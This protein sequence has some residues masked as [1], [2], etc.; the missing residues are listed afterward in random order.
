MRPTPILKPIGSSLFVVYPPC[1]S[2][3]G[4]TLEFSRLVEGRDTITAEITIVT[5]GAGEIAWDRINLLAARTRQA[6]A[7]AADEK[8]PEAPWREV[9]EESCRLVVKRL[10]AGEP[11]VELLPQ[12]PTPE[13]Q[14]LVKGLIFRNEVNLVFADG[15]STKSLFALALTM[16]GIL[17]HPLSPVWTVAPVTKGLYLDWESNQGAH[18]KRLWSLC[19]SMERP[20][21]G[22]ILYRRMTRPL[23]DQL[24][25]IQAECDRRGVDLVVADS[26]APA[27]GPEPEGGDASIRTLQAL[28]SLGR[29]VVCLAHMSK[30][31]ADGNAEPRPYGSV[32][33]TNLARS[34]IQLKPEAEPAE[35]NGRRVVTMVHRK[36]N[37]G[38]FMPPSSLEWE[39]LPSGEIRCHG[40]SVSPEYLSLKRRIQDAIAHGRET[41]GVIADLVGA[42]QDA[43]RVALNEMKTVGMVLRFG[44]SNGG[45]GNKVLWGLVDRN[46]RGEEC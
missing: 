34:T 12:E 45:R 17:G 19:H 15:G 18:A 32:F 36:V 2:C 26:L 22:S 11:S 8:S 13:E 14:C 28:R 5:E 16:A 3:A 29:T 4:I 33:N 6:L 24:D 9:V 38:R 39:F 25:S 46:R 40:T 30:N 42:K 20:A 37:D 41:V 10:R 7:R 1:D 31:S 43:V 35:A 21:D 44:D 27:S 23:V